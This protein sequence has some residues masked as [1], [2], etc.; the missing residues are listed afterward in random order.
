MRDR[1][2]RVAGHS[3]SPVTLLLD[4]TQTISV[5]IWRSTGTDGAWV[6]QID[7][8]SEPDEMPLRINLNE[9]VVHGPE[10]SDE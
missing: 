6:V 4:D 9:A 7:T 3:Y 8:T 2:A 10:W 1:L 5:D